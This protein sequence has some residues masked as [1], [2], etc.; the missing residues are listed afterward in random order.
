[1]LRSLKILETYSIHALDGD[2]GKLEQLF[3]DDEQWRVR[4]LVVKTGRFFHRAKVLISIHGLKK[5]DWPGS[6]FEVNLTREQIESSPEIEVE[7]LP[8]RRQE[9]EYFNYY[10][11]PYYWG[12][13]GIW[14]IAPLEMVPFELEIADPHL[15]STQSARECKIEAMDETLGSVVDLM[16]DDDRWSIKYLVVDTGLLRDTRLMLIPSEQINGVDWRLRV[17]SS[18]LPLDYFRNSPIFYPLAPH[19]REFEQRLKGYFQ[20]V[21]KVS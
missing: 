18:D 19:T 11:W 6:R 15:S 3:F 2:L 7:H 16:V 13:S 5:I 4:Y 1:M 8:S 9:I 10:R 14:G 12:Q 20:K 21:K 17:M